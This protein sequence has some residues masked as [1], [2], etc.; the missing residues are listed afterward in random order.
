[1]ENMRSLMAT[2]VNCTISLAELL[3]LRPNMW[4]DLESCLG[5]LGVKDPNN[6][7]KLENDD[8]QETTK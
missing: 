4:K 6:L 8:H 7:I 1:M 2:P 5:K 3:K